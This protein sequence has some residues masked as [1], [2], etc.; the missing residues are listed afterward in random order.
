MSTA[1][2]PGG[3]DYK[4]AKAQAKAAKAYAKAQRPWYK[5]KRF[6]IPLAIVAI[7][8]FVQLGKGGGDPQT[9]ATNTGSDTSS[10]APASGAAESSAP[11][12][13]EETADEPAEPEFTTSQQNAIQAAKDYLDYSAFSRQGLIEQLSSEYGD[14]YPRADAIFAVDHITVNYKQQA[15]RAAKEYLDYTSFSRAGLIQQLESKSGDRYTHAQAV[16]GVNHTG[17]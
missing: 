17:L 4:D 8:V 10:A 12:V 13:V 15:A 9:V 14:S 11:A 6:I 1:P 7:V 3:G 2:P 5:K 16:Y